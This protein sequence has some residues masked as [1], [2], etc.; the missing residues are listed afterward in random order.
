MRIL[1]KLQMTLLY[2]WCAQI[3]VVFVFDVIVVVIVVVFV[4]VVVFH[5][6]SRSRDAVVL[7]RKYN[8]STSSASYFL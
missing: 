3:F 8:C 7:N 6:R 1:I 2:L 5:C 4:L